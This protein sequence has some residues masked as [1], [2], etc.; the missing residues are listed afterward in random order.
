MQHFGNRNLLHKFGKVF[1]ALV[2]QMGM[3]IEILQKRGNFQPDG[4]IE[5]L[6][7]DLIFTHDLSIFIGSTILH[8]DKIRTAPTPKNE[9]KLVTCALVTFLIKHQNR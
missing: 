1:I 2:F 4:A 8:K 5:P 3:E 9:K 6:D 7:A